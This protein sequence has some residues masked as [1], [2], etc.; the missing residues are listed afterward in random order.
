M[1]TSAQ[2]GHLIFA[3]RADEASTSTP[4]RIYRGFA[5]YGRGSEAIGEFAKS[6]CLRG[7]GS[8]RNSDGPTFSRTLPRFG[9]VRDKPHSRLPGCQPFPFW[10]RTRVLDYSYREDTPAMNPA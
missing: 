8:D 5:G 6:G 9:A 3:D 7:S 4:N 10:S 1:G 2:N